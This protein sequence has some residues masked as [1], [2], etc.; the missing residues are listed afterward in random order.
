M[1][2]ASPSLPVTRPTH[3]K[4]ACAAWPSVPPP[5]FAPPS[6][7][8]AGQRYRLQPARAGQPQSLIIMASKVIAVCG[9]GPGVSQS[10]ARLFGSRRYKVALLSRTAGKLEKAAVGEPAQHTWIMFLPCLCAVPPGLLAVDRSSCFARALASLLLA[11]LRVLTAAW[12]APTRLRRCRPGC[13]GRGGCKETSSHT[14]PG[15]IRGQR[16]MDDVSIA[17]CPDRRATWTEHESCLPPRPPA[18]PCRAAGRGCRGDGVPMRPLRCR[19]A[20]R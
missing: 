13:P 11:L 9:Y 1:H 7:P 10:V 8:P 15:T 20:E 2:R 5:H 14:N 12:G 4:R 18:A 16:L 6:S 17:P 19:P 3:Y